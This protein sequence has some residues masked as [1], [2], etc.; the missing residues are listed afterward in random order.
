M[1]WITSYSGTKL[2]ELAMFF[3]NLNHGPI[4]GFGGAAHPGFPPAVKASPSRRCSVPKKHFH[5]LKEIKT[6]LT[7][8]KNKR[9]KW[10]PMGW[11][12]RAGLLEEATCLLRKTTSSTV[13][14]VA[15]SQCLSRWF[16]TTSRLSSFISLTSLFI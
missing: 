7:G 14:P 16:S 13:S 1:R 12:V 8:K 11:I 4:R 9:K 5:K 6:I 3:N 2:C 15:S 10:R